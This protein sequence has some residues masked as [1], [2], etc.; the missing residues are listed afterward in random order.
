VLRKHLG[1]VPI[2][3]DEVL[4]I[5][6]LIHASSILESSDL[7]DKAGNGAL[8]DIAQEQIGTSITQVF[9]TCRYKMGCII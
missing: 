5:S 1:F 9:S 6:S 8:L 3:L 4:R 7:K 2:G